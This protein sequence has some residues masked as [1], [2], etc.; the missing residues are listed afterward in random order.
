MDAQIAAVELST[1]ARA[2]IMD[3]PIPRRAR[4]VCIEDQ[5]HAD[6]LIALGRLGTNLNQ[7]AKVANATGNLPAVR[8]IRKAKEA[9]ETIGDMV[10]DALHP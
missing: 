10:R 6:I 7:L 1:F 5:K 8:E 3:G 9:L 2:R 4:R